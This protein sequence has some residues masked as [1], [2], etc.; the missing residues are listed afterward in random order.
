MAARPVLIAQISDLH[1]TPAGTLAYGRVDT[2]AA[3]TR[4]VDMINR[5]SPPPDLVVI[6][7]DIANS[8]LPEEYERASKLLG[9]LQ[10]PFAAIPG[11]HDR[12]TPMRRALPDPSYGTGESPLNAVRSVGEID[13]L[14]ID[15]TVA[16]AAHGELD[17]AT[18]A[19]L[20]GALT[21]S[22]TRP[23]LL[24]L[25]HPPFNTGIV[26]TDAIRLRNADALAALIKRHPRA[27]L[28]AAGHVHRAV[29]TVFAGVSATICPAGEQ[30]VKLEFAPR[31]PEVYRIEPPA[32]HLHAWLPGD[33]FGS[34][35]THVVPIGEF[36][37]PYPYG[38]SDTTPPR[39]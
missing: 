27:L 19:W 23:A 21:A 26:Y 5:M 32:L 13:V 11:N 12:R 35:V 36:P 31:W 20:D 4:A 6:S 24:F 16:G 18:L 37:G 34:V 25:H 3:L 38:Y 29:Q 17:A 15:S 8:A 9:D 39:L 28:V 33:G 1:I 30:A 10:M 14:L 22:A 7:G 2:A